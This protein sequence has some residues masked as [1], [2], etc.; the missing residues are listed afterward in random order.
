MEFKQTAFLLKPY[1]E[2]YTK[3]RKQEEKEGNKIKNGN[4]KLRNN[5]AFGKSLENSVNKLDVK[6]VISRKKYLKWSFRLIFRREKQLG[7]GLITKD[8]HFN[9]VINKYGDK[10]KLLFTDTDSFMCEIETENVN[11]DF[12]KGKEF[13]DFNKYSKD[14]K[15]YDEIDKIKY[16]T[17]GGSIKSFALLKRKNVYLYNRRRT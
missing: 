11:E 12:Y 3:L 10:P 16:K 6:I 14:S 1:I 9:Y 4:A 15:Y 8:F 2:R 5:D 7:N 17:C 13:I